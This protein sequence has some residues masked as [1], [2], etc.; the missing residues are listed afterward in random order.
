[1]DNITYIGK[2]I[3]INDDIFVDTSA[4]MDT[5]WFRQFLMRAEPIFKK[6]GK[7]MTI[8][9]GVRSELV[10]HLDS[11]E[12]EKRSKAWEAVSIL[13]EYKGL[14]QATPGMLD[15]DDIAQAFADRELL[16]TLMTNRDQHR[17][18]L[19]VNDKKLARDAFDLNGLQ[20]CQGSQIY[21][22]YIDRFGQLQ[23]CS[24]VN[25][26]RQKQTPGCE[27]NFDD[28]QK[29]DST[30]AEGQNI[31]SAEA[32]LSA[33][34]ET[35]PAQTDVDDAMSMPKTTSKAESGSPTPKRSKWWMWLLVFS[36]GAAAGFYT[37]IYRNEI[38]QMFA[39]SLTT[40]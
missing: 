12:D 16:I 11:M 29:Y 4:L 19:I 35:T 37:G 13:T 24:C 15:D 25:E 3:E 9:P 1:M 33:P 39:N 6:A 36:G 23:T 22:C 27:S 8:S 14:F 31:S 21:V 7:R 20:S 2:M 26:A 17:Q 10:R 28:L 18:L 30:K 34:E 38:A 5:E 40:I 32:A